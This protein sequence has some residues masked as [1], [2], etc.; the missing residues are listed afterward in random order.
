MIKHVILLSALLLSGVAGSAFADAPAPSDEELAVSVK[1]ALDADA[2]LKPLNLTVVS[3][4]SEVT[5]QGKMTDDQQM[6]KAG[7]IAEKVPGVKFVINKM[8]P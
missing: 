6:F 8:E 4:K 2:D 7:Q 1:Q 3:Q 5:I